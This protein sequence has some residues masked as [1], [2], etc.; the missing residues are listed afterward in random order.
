MRLSVA[1]ELPTIPEVPHRDS[2]YHFLVG[3][4]TKESHHLVDSHISWPQ[5]SPAFP[6]NTL[7][8]VD[9]FVQLCS[10]Q[11]AVTGN[12]QSEWA[13]VIIARHAVYHQDHITCA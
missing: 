11:R 6:S 9:G 8:H 3:A 2:G 4:M 1:L 5:F 7:L 13:Q 10:S 12:L